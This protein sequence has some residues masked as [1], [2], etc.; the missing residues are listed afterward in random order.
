LLSQRKADT[1]SEG[2]TGLFCGW[3]QQSG[4]IGTIYIESDDIQF[5][6]IEGFMDSLLRHTS[7]A[8]LCYNL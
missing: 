5:E 2:E 6:R 7:I 4:L 8:Q 1:V 3:P